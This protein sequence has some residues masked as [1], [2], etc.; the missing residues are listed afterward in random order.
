MKKTIALL[1]ALCLS[2]GLL[3]GCGAENSANEVSVSQSAPEVESVETS[4]AAPAVEE[5]TSEAV[6]QDSVLESTETPQEEPT[7]IRLGGLK[8]PTSMGMVKLLDDAQQGTTENTYEFTMAGSA[9]ELTPKLLQGELD[10]LAVPSNL[11]AILYNNSD[12]QVQMLAINTL[13]VIYVVEKG[14]TTITSIEDLKGKTIYATGKGSTPEYALSFLLSQ[15]GLSMDD[16]NVEFKSEPTEVVAAMANEEHAIAMLPQPFVTVAQNQLEDLSV[17]LDL[18][19]EWDKLDVD[20]TFITASLIVRKEFAE[21]YPQQLA[22]FLQEFEASTQYVNENVSE[23][24]QLV[25]QFDIVKA[26]IAEKAIPYCNIVCITGEEMKTAAQGYLATLMEQNPQS[27]GGALP[28]DDFY[29][30]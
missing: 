24:A 19:E 2:I 18:T 5:E 17:V 10:I 4:E 9:D 28:G 29:Y 30:E 22:T 13:G 27:V 14:E 12:G 16:L 23:A 1:L 20:S 21:K 11:G 26:A 6:S 3:A 7:T 25:E 8:G 15:H